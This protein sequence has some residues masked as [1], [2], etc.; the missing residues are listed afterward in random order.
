MERGRAKQVT[1]ARLI[2]LQD[3]VVVVAPTFMRVCVSVTLVPKRASKA[4]PKRRQLRIT[5]FVFLKRA[6]VDPFNVQSRYFFVDL[7]RFQEVS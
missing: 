6:T 1:R 7:M 3:S 5:S 4:L 2:S